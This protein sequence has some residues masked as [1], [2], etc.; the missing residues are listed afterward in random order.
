MTTAN[1]IPDRGDPLLALLA[2]LPRA[3]PSDA[4]NAR[5]RSRSQAVLEQAL[6]RQRSRASRAFGWPLD[7]VV[8][9]GCVLYLAGG[10]AQAL[11]IVQGR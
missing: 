1:D 9:L 3:T 2:K 11:T 7:A 8:L 10:V 4:S 5:I 6:E